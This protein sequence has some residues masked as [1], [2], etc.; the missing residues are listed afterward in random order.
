MIGDN[1]IEILFIKVDEK[2][3]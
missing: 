1:W 3:S 2:E